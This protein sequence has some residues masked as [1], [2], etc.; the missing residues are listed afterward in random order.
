VVTAALAAGVRRLVFVSSVKAMGEGGATRVPEDAEPRPTTPYG[1]SKLAAERL[2]T[3]AGSRLHVVCL[4]FPL[5]YGPGQRGNLPRLIAA[6]SAGLFPPPPRHGCRSMVHVGTAVDALVEVARDGRA[7]GGTYVVADADPYTTRQLYDWIRE[8]LGWRPRLWATPLPVL[9]AAAFAGDFA[10]RLLGEVP[11]DS[12]AFDKLFG[13]AWYAAD[14]I[15]R[16]LG[17]RP[18]R[19]LQESMP[20]LV[21]DFQ[22]R[23]AAERSRRN[24]E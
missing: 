16:D 19:T 8:A 5:V 15:G 12:A 23:H 22:Q 14:R 18:W 2:V 17:L 20:G 13:S 11:F 21:A 6:V 9:R 3:A 24:A 7:A 10:A 4:R 1:R